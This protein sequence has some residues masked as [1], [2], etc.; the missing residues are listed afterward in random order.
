VA[1]VRRAEVTA[2]YGRPDLAASIR[3]ALRAA[4]GERE[5]YEPAELAGF[6][7]LHTLGAAATERLAQVAEVRSG[8]RVLDVGGG[9][10]GAAR[11]LAASLDCHVTLVDVTAQLCEA[12][13]LLNRL[14]GLSDRVAVRLADVLA[15]D[16]PRAS[17]DVAW[18]QHVTMHVADKARLFEVLRAAL[19][20]GGRMALWE[21][22]AGPAG[23]PHLPVPWADTA[24]QSLLVPSDEL[25]R[26]A[27][28][29]GLRELVW[30]DVSREAVRQMAAGGGGAGRT[31]P[32]PGLVIDRMPARQVN[33]FRN[34]DEG[35]T[36]LIMA[37]LA[38]G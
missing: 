7:Q 22:A 19:A 26:T 28:G 23:P 4:H 15:L 12:A 37:V 18:L 9:L 32:G 30:E 21:I 24:E 34:L 36:A 29:A 2:H 17:F 25:R 1:D 8:E 31:G 14:T 33:H 20:P 6:D 35:R 13:E 11:Q 5:R 38:A 16:V 27:A 3:D 10:G